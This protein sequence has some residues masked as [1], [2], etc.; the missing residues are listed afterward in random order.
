MVSLWEHLSDELNYNV[1]FSQRG[2]LTLGHSDADMTILAQRG[3]ATLA[4]AGESALARIAAVLPP[5]AR[6]VL[7][8]PVSLPGP[9]RAP[10]PRGSLAIDDLR[11]AVRGQRK[12]RFAYVDQ[13]YERT[14]RTVWPLAIG[15]LENAQ[16]LLGWCELRQGFRMFRV[17]R[18]AGGGETGERYP[19]RRA[20]LMKRWR[21]EERIPD[22]GGFIPDRN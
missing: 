9:R 13:H 17:D 2:S 11:A 4:K 6:A 10:M 22:G 19:G 21:L 1:M 20:E 7:E 18:I 3:D 15:F 5:D 12:L 14:R 8:S 16:I